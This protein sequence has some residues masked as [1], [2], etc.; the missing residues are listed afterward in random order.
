MTSLSSWRLY[1]PGVDWSNGERAISKWRCADQET[2]PNKIPVG[3]VDAKGC[4]AQD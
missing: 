3:Q 1:P 4:A 2:M